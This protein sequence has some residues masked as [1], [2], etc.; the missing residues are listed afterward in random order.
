LSHFPGEE[1]ASALVSTFDRM[2]LD[3]RREAVIALVKSGGSAL[4][5]ALKG[6]A[7]GSSDVAAGCFEALRQIG[8]APVETLKDFAESGRSPEWVIWLLA[9]LPRSRVMPA[10]SAWQISRPD[11]YFAIS[12]LWSFFESWVSET[13]EVNPGSRA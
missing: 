6:L 10:I 8:T 4:E 12:V 2:E 11:L 7:E 13:W 3:L 5:P 1:A 9:S